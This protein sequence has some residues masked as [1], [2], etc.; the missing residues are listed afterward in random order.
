M[1]RILIITEYFY[2]YIYLRHV[3][4]KHLPDYK[5]KKINVATSIK[6]TEHTVVITININ[7]LI[8]GF[9]ILNSH[10]NIPVSN[11]IIIGDNHPLQQRN[12][13]WYP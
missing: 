8:L 7:A 13:A 10:A 3:L 6:I 11:I 9:L 2:T 1:K 12:T 4:D 5:L